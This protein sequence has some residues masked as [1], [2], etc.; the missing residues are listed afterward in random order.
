ME[1]KPPRFKEYQ[2][3]YVLVYFMSRTRLRI[4]EALA[5]KWS[6]I[7]GNR[8]NIDRQTS[9]DDN[10]ILDFTTL[11]TISSYRNIEIDDETVGLLAMFRKTQ[12]KMV[13]KH[14]KFKRN[15]DMIIFQTYNVNYMTPSTVRET[16]MGYCLNAGVEYK[17]THGFRHTHAVLSLEAGADLLYIS[18]RFGHAS[19]KTTVDTY[20]DF[21]PQYESG[22]LKKITTYLNSD[23]A[24][25]WQN[26]KI[27]PCH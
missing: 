22:E 15:K 7:V 3:Y 21:T 12:Q 5:L 25:T 11:K 4:S 2:I 26:D 1:Y 20:L 6:D 16:L 23:M 27:N 24:Q 18:R 14:K 17:G 10:N 19:I 9:R 13:L 8:I